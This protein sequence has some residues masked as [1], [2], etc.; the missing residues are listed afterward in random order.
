MSQPSA[1]NNNTH[2][3]TLLNT[4]NY[5]YMLAQYTQLVPP[6]QIIDPTITRK[7]IILELIKN[8]TQVN[9]A[10]STTPTPYIH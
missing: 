5:N 9:Q 2:K 3:P 4:P 10:N 8:K 7:Y 1:K 6:S